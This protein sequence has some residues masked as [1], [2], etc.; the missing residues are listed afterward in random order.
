MDARRHCGRRHSLRSHALTWA[1]VGLVVA[2]TALLVC[3]SSASAASTSAPDYTAID[4]YVSGSLGG[5]PGFAIS[6]VHGDQVVHTRGF[7]VADSTGAP[8]TADTPLAI[9]SQTKS[10]T[11]MAIMQL[12][13]KGALSLDSPV[14]RYL[15]WF[16]VADPMYSNQITLREL[17]NQTSGLP[18]SAPFN[19]PVTNA[20][21]RVRDLATVNLTAAPGQVW[22]YSNANYVILGLVIGAV[23]G[24]PYADYLREHVFTPLAMKHTFAS[25][26]E[27][28]RNGL[29]TGHQVWFGVPVDADTYRSDYIAAGW[30]TSSVGDMGNY[31]IAQLNG[32]TY[33]GRSVLSAQGIEE[34]H[35]GVSKVSTGGSYGMGWLA[36]SLN[37]VPV[38]SHD[39]DALNMNSDMVLVPSLSWAVELVA[40]SDSLPVLLSA[41][42]T[43]TVKGVVSMLMGLKA[44]FTASPLVTYIVFDLLVLALLGFQVWSLVRA[45]GRSQ[46][47]WRSGW[48]SILRRAALTLGWRLVV[49]TAL[50]GLLWL[51]AAQ[52]GASPL[53][54]VN[55][56]LGVSIVA[57]AVLLLV[58]GAV[59]TARAYIAAQ[60]VTTLTEPLAPSSAAAWSRR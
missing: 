36:D 58:N 9:G 50:I 54:I 43:S 57:I 56:D 25:E 27:A 2:P 29:A 26:P 48:A 20:E 10:I 38:V 5:T 53:L 42:V 34:M 11:A 23:S 41:S 39:G 55:T 35:R 12:S 3:V 30:L 59:R 28:M 45:V 6:I 47:P 21:S 32:G 17:L 60:S 13:E 14:Q 46:R 19:T 49:A 37:G 16:R 18:P 1:V 44:P 22:Q 52:L 40:T 31:L 51:L 4:S 7:G 15:P 8:M 24:E 33:A